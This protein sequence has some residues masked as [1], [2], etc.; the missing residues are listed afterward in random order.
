MLQLKESSKSFKNISDKW[1]HPDFSISI[2]YNFMKKTDI[3]AKLP[4]K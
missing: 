1:M 4:R 3:I 2:M